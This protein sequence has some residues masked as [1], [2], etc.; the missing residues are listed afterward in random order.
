MISVCKLI[1]LVARINI[2][3]AKQ[4]SKKRFYEQC[5]KVSEISYMIDW[6]RLPGKRALAII[7]VITMSNSSIKLT[8]GNLIDLSLS[9]F[10]DVSKELWIL[11]DYLLSINF[12]SILFTNKILT[13]NLFC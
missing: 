12:L 2:L 11:I 9:S 3:H 6:H 7:L 5:K 13:Y 1:L 10:G 8:A 4:I